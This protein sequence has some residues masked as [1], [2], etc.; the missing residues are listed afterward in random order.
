MIISASRRTDIPAHYADWFLERVREGFAL[1]RNPRNAHQIRRVSLRPEDVDGIVFW[2]KNPLPMLSRLKELSAYAY[3]FQAT[4]TPYGPDVE[5]GIP[6]KEKVILPS[7]LRLS[8]EIGPGRVVWRCD[9]I[10]LSDR[11]TKE[12][13]YQAFDSMARRLAGRVARCTISFLDMYKNTARN[14]QAMGLAPAFEADM[15]EMAEKIAAIAKTHGIPVDACAE[16]LDFSRFGMGRAGC[17]DPAILEAASGRPIAFKRQKGQRPGCGCADSVD[18]GAYNS[19]PNGCGY[20]Y[21]NFSPSLTRENLAR[22]DNHSP[23]LCGRLDGTP[24]RLRTPERRTLAA[25]PS[26]TLNVREPRSAAHLPL[27]CGR[28]QLKRKVRRISQ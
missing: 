22:H 13:H 24:E 19:C 17:V 28:R 10:L 16:P 11:Y 12:F 15:L 6:D 21:A 1:V 14:A 23:L 9:P 25:F 26:G 8:D 20:C 3:Y 4:V 7:L 18:I 27:L 2:T 5:P